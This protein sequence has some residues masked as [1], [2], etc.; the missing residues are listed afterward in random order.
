MAK[1]RKALG[2]GLGALI[3]GA[4]DAA[5][6]RARPEEP[7]NQGA[8][9]RVLEIQ[10]SSV[11]PNP[12]QPRTHFDEDSVEELAQSIRERGI[13]Q[14]ISVRQFGD[15]F[16]LIAGERRLRAARKAQLATVPAIVLDVNSD[17]ELMEISLVENVQREN[18]NPIEEARAYRALMEECF[19][20]QEEVAQRVGKERSTVANTLRLLNLASEVREALMKGQISMGHARALLGLDDERAQTSLCAQTIDRGLS[21]RRVEELVRQKREP[22]GETPKPKPR[23]ADP[24]ILSIEEDLQRRFGTGVNIKRSGDRGRIEIEY[25]SNDDLERI[26]E[27]LSD[28]G[29]A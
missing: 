22:G 3:P 4:A 23:A 11:E 24:Q 5:T 6:D 20:T 2:K 16:Q 29:F 14:P 13:I 19:L 1:Q 15:G 7:A 27:I 9:Q 8:G 21:V 28:T 25:Y 26:I 10:V 18:L 17:E 12:H